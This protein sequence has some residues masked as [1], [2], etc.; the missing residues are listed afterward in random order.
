MN[1]QRQPTIRKFNPGLFQTDHEVI[2]QFAVRHVEFKTVLEIIKENL[3]SPSWQHVLVVAPR[4]LG[5]T[6]LLARLA[7]E[8]R[9]SEKYSRR[10]VPIRLMEECYEIFTIADF[11]LEALI[12]LAKEI[13]ARDPEASRELKRAHAE[14][15]SRWRE[16]DIAERARAAVL[17]TAERLDWHLV[18]MVEN[19]QSLVDAVDEDFGWGLRHA[20]QIESRLTLV[21]TATS[22][23]RALGDVEHAFFELFRPVRLNPLDLKSCHRLWHELGGGKRSET[24]MEP[25]RILTGGSPRLLAMIASFASHFSLDRLLDEFVDLIDGHTEYFR[26]RLDGMPKTERRV[27]LA[28]ADLWRPSRTSEV[29]A[30]A[31]LGIRTVSTMLGR[32]AD[33]GA[34]LVGGT[35]GK[36]EYSVAEG[37]YCLYYKLRRD[38]DAVHVVSDL[39][40][41]M[42]LVFAERE[43]KQ[44]LGTH[45]VLLHGVQP[46]IPDEPIV[47]KLIPSE[48]LIDHGSSGQKETPTG[49]ISAIE[50]IDAAFKELD[51]ERVVGMANQAL[52]EWKD[53]SGTDQHVARQVILASILQASALADVGPV[54]SALRK[55]DDIDDILSRIPEQMRNFDLRLLSWVRFKAYAL[56]EDYASA[57]LALQSALS[58][59]DL[60]G[61]D[62]VQELLCF[63]VD[64]IARGTPEQYFL[65]YF[66]SDQ[67]RSERLA[68]ILVALKRRANL[69]ARAPAEIVAVADGIQKMIEVRRIAILERNLNRIGS[70]RRNDVATSGISS[71]S[72]VAARTFPSA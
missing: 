25:L 27:Y 23:F 56:L 4:G 19:L 35:G 5:K 18:L 55:C 17:S 9:T 57:T 15:K 32:L 47:D 1:H 51:F 30:R 31:S 53:F 20:L 16:R 69:S 11:W 64:A 58:K 43:Q 66:D 24:E 34:V 37:L 38:Q 62:D 36:R 39:I 44:V 28:L 7:A 46:A 70:L 8:F 67:D 6:M 42:R 22:Y 45:H 2:A 14:F 3:D 72:P 54:N 61:D 29:A 50:G 40:R 10:V 68:P 52:E 41:F 60:D 33:R 65:E 49:G 12:S 71:A 63:I 21:A 13:A 26:G 59:C 48:L